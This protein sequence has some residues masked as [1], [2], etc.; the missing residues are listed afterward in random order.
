MIGYV[1]LTLLWQI[2]KKYIRDKL[3]YQNLDEPNESEIA[4]HAD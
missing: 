3:P 4:R 2:E 1:L